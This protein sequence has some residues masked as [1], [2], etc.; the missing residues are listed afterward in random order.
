MNPEHEQRLEAVRQKCV[1]ANPDINLVY[2]GEEKGKPL[3]AGRSPTLADVL[4]AVAHKDHDLFVNEQG[5]MCGDSMRAE[6]WTQIMDRDDAHWNL[7]Q[8]SLDQQSEPTITFLHQLL[9]Q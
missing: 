4:L 7:R 5:G 2:L 6:G 3:Y 8:D 1:E 9:C